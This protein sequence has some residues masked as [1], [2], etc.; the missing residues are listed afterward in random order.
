[1]PKEFPEED[2]KMY[3]ILTERDRVSDRLVKQVRTKEKLFF[4][5]T[6]LCSFRFILLLPLMDGML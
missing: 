5:S 1:L 2:E 4:I 6:Q 3:E